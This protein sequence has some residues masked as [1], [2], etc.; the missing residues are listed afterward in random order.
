MRCPD[1]AHI[2]MCFLMQVVA[3]GPHVSQKLDS[4][5]FLTCFFSDPYGKDVP[6]KISR[7]SDKYRYE[8]SPR[9][10]GKYLVNVDVEYTALPGSPF[11]YFVQPSSGVVVTDV[12]EEG[13][14]GEEMYFIGEN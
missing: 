11:V 2:L 7:D 6:L 3:R 13:E 12:T 9:H 8:F 4:Y 1:T 10:T 5:Y 14:V